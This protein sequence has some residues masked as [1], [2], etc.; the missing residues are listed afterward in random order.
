M[1][2]NLNNPDLDEK[3]KALLIC[4]HYPDMDKTEAETHISELESLVDTRG[5]EVAGSLI[6][7]LK[8]RSPKYFVGSGKADE[9]A[10]L[11]EKLE[12]ELIIFDNELSPAQQRN[13]EE[14]TE[15]C[16]IDRHEVILDIFAGR[17]TTKEAVLQVG[18]ARMEYSLPRLTRAWTH[19]SRQ[20]GGTKGTRGEGETQL[21]VDRRIVLNKITR[22][23]KDLVKVREHRKTLRKQR[24]T[25]PVPTGAI[26]GYT[27]AGKSSLLNI[28]TGADAF[29]ENKLFATLDPTTRRVTLPGGQKFLLTD[30][31]GFIRKLPH[32][33]VDA[34]R[35]TLEETVLAD[36]LIHVLDISHPEVEEQYRITLEVLDNLGAG[37]KPMLVAFNKIDLK[38]N[39]PA[40]DNIGLNHP[41]S[42]YIST[43]T[44]EGIEK[45]SERIEELLN[46]DKKIVELLIPPD[47]YDLISMIH[48]EGTI[49][50]EKYNESGSV[51]K[52][53]IP[54]KIYTKL[55]KYLI[56]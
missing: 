46:K 32:D 25:I 16:V 30:T 27:N 19:L 49:L 2:K 17:A 50:Q 39:N 41:D 23:K 45:L 52:A 40:R 20:K 3:Q 28:L 33:L 38:N 5:A 7:P 53:R 10:E 29:V 56:T 15:K 37:D 55:E 35:S 4:I 24:S 43:K 47:R 12:A 14:L 8:K 44:G 22:L 9:V 1:D 36:F 42:L 11:A 34:F 21:E 6:V 51:I 26:V 13:L 18:L 48:R 54:G 31:V